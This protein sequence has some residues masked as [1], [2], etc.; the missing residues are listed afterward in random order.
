M[1]CRSAE[2]LYSAFLEDELNQ[3]ERR[4]FESHLL[5]CRRCSLAIRE[6]RAT[7]EMVQ[8]LPDV[9]TSPHFEEDVLARI[10][11]GEAMRP[12]V[13]DWLRGLLEPARLRPVFLAGAGA[14]A[15]WIAVLI[16]QTGHT[17]PGPVA[18][19]QPDAAT[20]PAAT[21]PAPEI[22]STPAPSSQAPEAALA[23]RPSN[24]PSAPSVPAS[25]RDAYAPERTW[26]TAPWAAGTSEAQDSVVPNPGA[27]YVDEYIMDQFYI[28]HAVEG[29]GASPSITPVSG[30]PSDDVEIQF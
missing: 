24:H 14:C 20:A 5:S 9:E 4:S 10:R 30:H 13:T 18:V 29:Q 17:V 2:A 23:S 26:A 15:V 7:I 16:S 19:K 1:N 11:S 21:T 27:R 22:A 8:D 28:D 12:S 25:Q 6:L 3:K